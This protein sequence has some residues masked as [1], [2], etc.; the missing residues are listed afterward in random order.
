MNIEIEKV[1]KLNNTKST[2]R[3]VFPFISNFNMLYEKY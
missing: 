2:G 1:I 3:I